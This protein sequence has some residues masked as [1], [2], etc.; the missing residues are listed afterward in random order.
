MNRITVTILISLAV[1]NL[2]QANETRMATL[3]AGPY[4][5]DIIN[6]G[7]Y[8]QHIM[9]YQNSLYGDITSTTE[10][11]GFIITPDAKYGALAFWESPSN[12]GGFDI[13]YAVKLANFDFGLFGSP[14]ENHKQIGFGIGRTFFTRRIDLSFIYRQIVNDDN[15]KLNLRLLKRKGDFAIIPMYQLQLLDGAFIDYSNHAIG[16]IVQRFVLNEG[17][18]FCGAEYDMTRGDLEAD[19]TIVHTGFEL[20]LSRILILRLGV[21]EEF[22]NGFD[23]GTW[24]VEPGISIRIREFNLDF[25]LNKER[26]YDKE[27]TFFKSFGIELDFGRF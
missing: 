2:A 23:P 1:L 3:M 6:I 4:I 10:D 9:F 24:Q 15:W 27:L 20:P 19:Q 16:L 25:H 14:I 13:G 17:F 18:V 7:I 26:L 8:P 21:K 12:A 22:A 5:D 11:Y